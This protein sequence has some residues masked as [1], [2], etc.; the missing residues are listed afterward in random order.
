MEPPAV[1]AVLKNDVLTKKVYLERILLFFLKNKN[2]IIEFT[3]D[4]VLFIYIRSLHQQTTKEVNFP[5]HYK[6]K[7]TVCRY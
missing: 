3:Y 5:L 6:L 2:E 7:S 1:V 4:F